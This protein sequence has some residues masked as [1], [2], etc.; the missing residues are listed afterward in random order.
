MK[1]LGRRRIKYSN[2]KLAVIM[3]SLFLQFICYNFT[4]CHLI[5]LKKTLS[6]FEEINGS[7]CCSLVLHEGS[8]VQCNI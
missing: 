5:K 1:I 4:M 3:D 7:I 2:R 6:S 8:A